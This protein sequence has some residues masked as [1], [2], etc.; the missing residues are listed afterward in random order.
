MLGVEGKGS[1]YRIVDDSGEDFCIRVALPRGLTVT[2]PTR[3]SRAR[4]R[5][6][7]AINRWTQLV[8]LRT[9]ISSIA[10]A[11]FSIVIRADARQKVET[12]RSGRAGIHHPAPLGLRDQL[13][14]RV[15]VHDDV[16]GIARQQLGRAW[17]PPTS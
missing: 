13:L 3:I 2:R 12:P 7:R 17:A 6:R 16:R 11:P 8:R 9:M 15:A 5:T 1:F 10:T 14:V 4:L